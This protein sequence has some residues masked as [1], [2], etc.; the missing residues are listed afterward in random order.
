MVLQ[1]LPVGD[2]VM[3]DRYV[4]VASIGFFLAIAFFIH[5]L[6]QKK[7]KLRPFLIASFTLYCA[8]ICIKTYQRIGIWK[9]SQTLWEDA[10]QNYPDNNDR[11]L[12]N[13][14][15]VFFEKHDY[16]KALRYYNRILQIPSRNN[17]AVSKAFIG[18]ARVDQACGNFPQALQDFT[19]S[20]AYMESYDAYLDRS[21]LKNEMEDPQGALKDLENAMKLDPLS[22]GPYINRGG[23]YYQMGNYAEA[24]Q[25]FNKVLDVDPN[26]SKAYIGIGQV[27]QALHE[28]EVAMDY[29][30]KSLL[31]SPSYE[32]YLTRAV[33][34]IEV[35]DY[36]GARADL[37]KAYQFDSLSV[38]LY[39]NKG[40]VELNSGNA[41]HS[42]KEFDNAVKLN[43]GNYVVYLY[44]AIA[45]NEAKDYVGAIADLTV[46]IQLH[47]SAEAYYYRSVAHQQLKH[48]LQ[49]HE[50]LKQSAIMGNTVAQEDIKRNYK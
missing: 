40:V 42:L 32:G 49:A 5:F 11:G 24:I 1:V 16:D 23:I 28:N 15:N 44:R 46:S 8:I 45:K 37:N 6:W 35:K 13:L 2:A 26:N 22:T 17:K 20:L 7:D 30:N 3:A 21:V 4:Y 25:N 39:I 38:E 31:L 9:N 27:K 34:R 12:Q 47:P 29:F 36:D 43:P 41:I 19:T 18:K 10:L 33:L 48:T 50:D 14:G